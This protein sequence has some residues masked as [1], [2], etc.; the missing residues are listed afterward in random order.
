MIVISCSLDSTLKQAKLQ[1][2]LR[3]LAERYRMFRT[4]DHV[5]VLTQDTQDFTDELAGVAHAPCAYSRF[6]AAR[7]VFSKMGF[8][9]WA[10]FSFSSFL[11]LVRN[12]RQINL[13]IS[14]NVDSPSPLIFSLLFRIPYCIHYRYDVATQVR[15]VNKRRLEGVLLLFL[16]RLGFKR[17]TLVWVTAGNLGEKAKSLGARKVTWVPNWI[18]FSEKPKSRVSRHA[19]PAVLFVGRLHP[20]K[21]ADVLIKAFAQVQKAHPEASLQIIGDGEERQNLETLAKKLEL[22]SHV[23][24]LGFQGREKVFN[25]MRHSDIIVL[26]SKMEGNPRVLLEAMMMK[27]PIVATNAPGIRD[28]VQHAKTGHLISEPTPEKLALGMEYVLA[29]RKYAVTIAENAFRFAKQQFSKKNIVEN[30]RKDLVSNIPGFRDKASLIGQIIAREER[31][32][33]SLS[34][35][36]PAYNAEKTLEKCLDSVIQA[37]PT[38]K[39]VIVVDDGSTDQTCKIASNFPVKLLSF[40]QNRGQSA[41]KNHGLAK[42]KGEIVAFVDSDCVVEQNYFA[43]LASALERAEGNLGGVGGVIYPLEKNM[44]SDSFQVR[45]F[46]FSPS[47][48]TNIRKT[49]CLGGGASA[50]LKE[51]LLKIGEFDISIKGG[52][53]LDMCIRLRKAGYKLLLVPSAKSY[54]LHPSSI[55]QLVKKWFHYG[56]SL[57]EVAHKNNLKKDIILSWGWVSS[58]LVICTAALYTGQPLVWLL[59]ALTFCLPWILNYGWQ[60]AEFWI[61]NRKIKYLALPLIHQVVILSRSLGVMA[62]TLTQLSKTKKDLS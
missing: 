37:S 36:I 20:V 27:L 4:F 15:K 58:C 56:Q 5:T 40:N 24:F 44:I 45:F 32:Y 1:G 49:D 54:H 47:G 52:E 8:L 61:R 30:I 2:N 21:Q 13:L 12:R 42:A 28:I 22:N 17:A 33:S 7:K 41:A 57:V 59:F 35:I 53:D 51:S 29:N 18:D 62:A 31:H 39:E 55:R 23:H 38:E 25:A 16:E 34:V 19:P 48:E 60:T 50:Y 6:E 11:W 3:A 43:E 9:R 10:Y 26:P 14:E 46:G